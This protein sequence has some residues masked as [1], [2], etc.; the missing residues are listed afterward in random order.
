MHY[1]NIS[2]SLGSCRASGRSRAVV[3]VPG[4][5]QHSSVFSLFG[6]ICLHGPVPLL[7]LGG[8][9]SYLHLQEKLCY[10]QQLR[11]SRMRQGAPLDFHTANK[12]SFAVTPRAA[13]GCRA[14]LAGL[15]AHCAWGHLRGGRC[16][17]NS[18]FLTAT[19]PVASLCCFGN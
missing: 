6:I 17:G 18:W 8:S 11:L 14:R 7:D 1:R 16:G 15:A 9:C 12:C 4:Y 10:W 5:S 13:Q 2:I 3:L 19:L